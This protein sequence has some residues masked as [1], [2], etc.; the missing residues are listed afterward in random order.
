LFAFEGDGIIRDFPGNYSQYREA[1]AKGLLEKNPQQIMKA[2]AEPADNKTASAPIEKATVSKKLSFKEKF[3]LETLEKELPALQK[4]KQHLEEKMNGNLSFEEL[5]A[6]ANR[7][8][9]II[10]ELDEKEMRWLELSEKES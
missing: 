7:I 8:G 1:A 5:E 4:E 2:A 9:I 10:K 3:E 6:A